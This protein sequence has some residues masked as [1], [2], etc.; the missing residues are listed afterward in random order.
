VDV[1]TI[2]ERRQNVKTKIVAH[3]T[4]GRGSARANNKWLTSIK[5]K[6]VIAHHGWQ[7]ENE[8][9]QAF[10]ASPDKQIGNCAECGG[11]KMAE[12]CGTSCCG[13]N[14]GAMAHAI[15]EAKYD[16]DLEIPFRGIAVYHMLTATAEKH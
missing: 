11:E 14:Q 12:R 1:L 15:D 16:D 4:A 13:C 3:T 10:F 2:A 7:G 5:T 6:S 8:L 9:G